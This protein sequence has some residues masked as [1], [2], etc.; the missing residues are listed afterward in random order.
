MYLSCLLYLNIENAKLHKKVEKNHFLLNN[1][2]DAHFETFFNI[3]QTVDFQRFAKKL[4]K[5]PKK[6]RKKWYVILK[7][8]V[9]LQRFNK[10]MIVLQI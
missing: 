4:Q 8:A 1:K 5:R 3:S 7:K 9:T 6:N 10:Q 2:Q